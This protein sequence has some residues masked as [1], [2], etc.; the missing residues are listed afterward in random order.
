MMHIA[1]IT[2]EYP[3]VSLP[4]AGGIGSFIKLMGTSLLKNKHQV[5]VFLCLSNRDKIWHD[6]NIRIVEIKKGTPSR[7]SPITD[8]LHINTRIKNHIKKDKIDIVEAA[9]WEGMHAFCNFNIPLV[10]RIHGSVTYFN[11]LQGLKRPRLLYYLEKRAIK[12]SQHVVAVSNFSGEITKVVFSF[13]KFNFETIYN[14]IDINTF[15]PAS[16]ASSNNKNI[17][18]FGTLVRKKGVI[19]LAHIFNTLHLINPKATLTLIGKDTID[20]LENTSTW[21]LMK[22]VLTVS[23]RNQVVYKGVI[24]YESMSEEIASCAVCVFPSFAEAFPISWLEAMAMQKPIVASSIGWANESIEDGES[25]LLEHPENYTEF[26]KKINSLL[27][28]KA[29]ATRLGTNARQRVIRLF[30]QSKLVNQNINMYKNI[31]N[32]E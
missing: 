8:R 23:A 28:D 31:L 24:P 2:T 4:S 15:K 22:T 30:D 17:L 20:G 29:I 16:E 32:N 7:L 19:A 27:T 21:E 9:D 13:K 5:T 1:Y 11:N 14:G 25:G 12:K 26:A 10:T 6:N 3:H 18:Y